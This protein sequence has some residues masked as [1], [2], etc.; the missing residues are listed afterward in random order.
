MRLRLRHGTSARLSVRARTQP[1][2]RPRDD[3]RARGHVLSR[4][5]DSDAGDGRAGART[6]TISDQQLSPRARHCAAA[7]WFAPDE[8]SRPR[9]ENLRPRWLRE[10]LPAEA[11]TGGTRWRPL[12]LRSV[13]GSGTATSTATE[14]RVDHLPRL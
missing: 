3:A 6:L 9:R 8:V 5:P 7:E 14:R 2:Y 11:I 10:S 12:L 13:Q 1:A 4:R